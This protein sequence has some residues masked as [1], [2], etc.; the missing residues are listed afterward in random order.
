M[1]TGFS[2]NA[3]RLFFVFSLLLTGSGLGLLGCDSKNASSA[4]AASPSTPSPI[5]SA[6]HAL[7]WTEAAR[8]LTLASATD[9]VAGVPLRYAG[10]EDCPLVYDFEVTTTTTLAAD[11]SSQA[12]SPGAPS[13]QAV[14]RNRPQTRQVLGR[15]ELRPGPAQAEPT[16]PGEEFV[17]WHVHGRQLGH[18]IVRNE[19]RM[20][21]QE[22]QE[23]ELENVV[24][25]NFG[26]ELRTTQPEPVLW[27][28]L[29]PFGGLAQF[30]P[31]LP[32]A[33]TQAGGPSAGQ[34]ALRVIERLFID[35]QPA[36]VLGATSDQFSG[37][38]VM[39]TSGQMLH[40]TTSQT[41][42]F[43]TEHG[44]FIRT[45]LAE[46]R[47]T[48]SCDGPTLPPIGQKTSRSRNA[49]D[50]YTR[51]VFAVHGDHTDRAFSFLSQDLV[52]A[53]GA[54]N[55]IALLKE[56]IDQYGINSLGDPRL[57]DPVDIDGRFLRF[58]VAG[59]A[60]NLPSEP[61]TPVTVINHI[62]IEDSESG[63][64]VLSIASTSQQTS[65]NW[66]MLEIS[67]R[68]IF[69]ASIAATP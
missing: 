6:E 27:N 61:N 13:G 50:T 58:R 34:P 18:Y 68:R 38:Y 10:S 15:F 64:R 32:A 49:L 44:E 19:I 20:P 47:L 31:G 59:R 48:G 66:N 43:S 24:L 51:L 36:L 25:Q 30:F 4:D 33:D 62:T 60:E 2:P 11:S 46:A 37:R 17:T 56:H 65:Q 55:I 54:E 29:H 39:L 21:G 45:Q 7:L 63:M 16:E 8:H 53:H 67:P 9:T 69:T 42:K 52:D 41:D 22:L 57:V 14:F 1:S 35:E 40:A 26:H 28:Q 12:A 23:D 3:I 5:T